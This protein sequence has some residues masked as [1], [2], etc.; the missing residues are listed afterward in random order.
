LIPWVGEPVMVAPEVV[1]SH[2]PGVSCV[3]SMTITLVAAR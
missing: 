3:M 1:G 2:R